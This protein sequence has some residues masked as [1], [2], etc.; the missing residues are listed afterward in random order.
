MPIPDDA[1]LGKLPLTSATPTVV[2]DTNVVLDW[3]LFDDPRV[4]ALAE[5]IVQGGAIWLGT[6][7]MREELA[8]VLDRGLAQQRR[9]ATV[10][11]LARWDAHAT[12]ADTPAPHP[13][14]CTDA[15]DQKFVDLSFAAPTR[16]L[17]TRDRALLRLA[18]RAALLGL[19]I[20][21][22]ERWR[23]SP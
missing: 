22:P 17:V 20:L 3:L 15:D 23:H 16:W 14:R 5:T 7:A 13:L 2:L 4:A 10:T 9:V 12:V 1:L 8:H 6:M 21:T 11:L 18:R 19:A